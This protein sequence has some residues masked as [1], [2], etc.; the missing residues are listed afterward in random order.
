M[1][2]LFQEN[3]CGQPVGLCDRASIYT[4]HNFNQF[5]QGRWLRHRNAGGFTN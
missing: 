1:K 3:P 4:T 5:G 2:I